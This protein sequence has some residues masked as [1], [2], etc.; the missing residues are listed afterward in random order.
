MWTAVSSSTGMLKNPWIWPWWRSI[1]SSAVRAGDADHVGDQARG[2]GDAW[3]VLLVRP[4]VRVV[5]H[6]RRDPPRAGALEGVDHDQ[7]L[8]DRLLNGAV[9]RLDDEDVAVAGVVLDAH[10]DVLVGE[11]EDLGPAQI[12]AQIAGNLRA[13]T[14]GWHCPCTGR[15]ARCKPS[16]HGCRKRSTGP[17]R[18]ACIVRHR[19]GACQP[20]TA[21]GFS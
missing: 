14:P 3:L 11:L 12:A 15:I 7:E 16:R 2:D 6:D 18:R 9:R 1:V 13:P 4:A 10:E 20:L 17:S 19:T 21:A 8:H 5:G